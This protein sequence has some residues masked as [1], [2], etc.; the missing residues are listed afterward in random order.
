MGYSQSPVRRAQGYLVALVEIRYRTLAEAEQEY[1]LVNHRCGGR[2]R[3]SL[4]ALLSSRH[5][6]DLG[7]T[8]QLIERLG[9]QNAYFCRG[10]LFALVERGGLGYYTA[11]HVMN[12]LAARW[13]KP[14]LA[15]FPPR[16]T[17]PL[18]PYGP[19][20]TIVKEVHAW[21]R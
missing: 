3:A 2:G 1:R 18:D 13:G 7:R 9:G 14:W 6:A 4:A 12:E 8:A 21:A 11:L 5:Q 20:V 19:R 10:Y 15:D 17:H 16:Q